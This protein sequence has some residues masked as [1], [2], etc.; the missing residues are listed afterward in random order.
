MTIVAN[1][2][3]LRIARYVRFSQNGSH[4]LSLRERSLLFLACNVTLSLLVIVLSLQLRRLH[5]K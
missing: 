5:S 4:T 1:N 3:I 2:E